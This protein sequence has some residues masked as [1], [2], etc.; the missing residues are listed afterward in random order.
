MKLFIIS[1]KK[2]RKFE[3]K[4]QEIGQ[5]FYQKIVD[6]Y[7]PLDFKF[8]ISNFYNRLDSPNFK[9]TQNKNHETNNMRQIFS[10]VVRSKL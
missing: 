7:R 6:D 8:G 5:D 2:N 4:G 3:K 10:Q 1:I 9:P